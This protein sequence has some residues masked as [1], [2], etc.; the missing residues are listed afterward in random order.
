MS[1]RLDVS[2]ETVARLIAEQFPQWADLPVS[3]V[4]HSGWDNRSF[5]LGEAMLVR[6]P[7]AAGYVPQVEKE[8]RWLPYL[9]KRLPLPIPEPLAKG[10]PSRI[11]P[12]RGPSI[13]GWTVS[14]WRC[15]CPVLIW[16]NW[17][18]MSRHS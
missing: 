5:R 8:H 6:L 15:S 13:A 10:K 12:F 9:A 14:H 3:P 17:P 4:R 2:I 7:S 18:V 11:I 1:D 16:C